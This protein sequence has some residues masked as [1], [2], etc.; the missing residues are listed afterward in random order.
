MVGPRGAEGHGAEDAP[1]QEGLPG[2]ETT[3]RQVGACRTGAGGGGRVF[4]ADV[5]WSCVNGRKKI[6][7]HKHN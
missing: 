3:L 6:M 1:G 7:A 2:K 4:Q 5:G